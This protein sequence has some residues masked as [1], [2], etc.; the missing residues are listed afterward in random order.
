MNDLELEHPTRERLAAFG[1]GQL[2]EEDLAE[3]EGH[4]AN[5]PACRQVAEGVAD[6]TLIVLLR[7]AAT[8]PVSVERKD[9][10]EPTTPM[11]PHAAGAPAAA[12]P[13]ALADHPR[14]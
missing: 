4:L 13:P 14:Y 1:L 9:V 6:D 10:P 2:N 11:A 5:C 12:L 7:S 3:V 8:E